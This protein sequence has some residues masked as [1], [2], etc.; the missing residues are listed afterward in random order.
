MDPYA[1]SAGGETVK[2]REETQISVFLGNHPGVVADI[3]SALTEHG[4]SIQA[5]TVLDTVDVGTMRMIVSDVE[6]TKSALKGSAAAFITVPV[7]CIDIPNT[8]G[9]FAKIA[10]TMS[11]AGVNIEYVYATAMP[12]SESTLGVFRVSDEATALQLEFAV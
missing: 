4:I 11:N 8:P 7:L 1:R 9:A 6:K 3:C 5:M 12:G 10:R 2:A